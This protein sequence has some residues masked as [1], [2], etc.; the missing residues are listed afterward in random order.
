MRASDKSLA[1]S[2]SLGGFGDLA[3]LGL[4]VAVMTIVRSFSQAIWR[5]S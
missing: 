1:F 4:E 2:G 3:D 5:E